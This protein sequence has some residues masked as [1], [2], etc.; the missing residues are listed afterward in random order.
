MVA[1]RRA[2]PAP[3]ARGRRRR[4]RR[5]GS[6]RSAPKAPAAPHGPPEGQLRAVLRARSR[7]TDAPCARAWETEA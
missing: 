2:P 7:S 1:T 3:R 6:V 5:A 4:P